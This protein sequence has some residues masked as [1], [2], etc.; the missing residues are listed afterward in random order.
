MAITAPLPIVAESEQKVRDSFRKSKGSQARGGIGVSATLAANEALDERRRRGERVLP[1]AFGEA[2]V[3]AAPVL[4][5]ALA[6]ATSRNEYGPVAGTP[7]VR[8]AVAGY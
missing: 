5:Y 4:R 1:M 7:E 6:S 8:E 2:G 3:P